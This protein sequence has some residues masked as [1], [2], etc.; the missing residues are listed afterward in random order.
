MRRGVRSSADHIMRCLS[1]PPVATN[2]PEEETATASIIAVWCMVDAAF[3]FPLLPFFEISL[4]GRLVGGG[5]A[6]EGALRE[7]G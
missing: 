2:L 6:L 5:G 1:A 4:V 3:D 7:I